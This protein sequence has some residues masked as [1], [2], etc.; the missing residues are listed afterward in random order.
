MLFFSKWNRV[1]LYWEVNVIKKKSPLGDFVFQ[2]RRTGSYT[3]LAAGFLILLADFAVS[4]FDILVSSA[5][6]FTLA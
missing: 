2:N 5:P 3:V 1:F 4:S 6:S